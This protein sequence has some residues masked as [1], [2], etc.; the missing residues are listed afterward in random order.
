MMKFRIQADALYKNLTAAMKLTDNFS[1]LL[2]KIRGDFGDKKNWTVIGGLQTAFITQGTSK[3]AA[4]KDLTSKYAADKA[5]DFP[6][7]TI[8]IRS[9]DM[10]N[11]LVGGKAGNVSILTKKKLEY[12]TMIPYAG[13]HQTGTKRMAARKWNNIT[14]LQVKTWKKLIASYVVDVLRGKQEGHI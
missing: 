2:L 1:P 13:F 7:K 3:G 4:W 10:F 5:K 6:G 9:G 12:G 14:P 8:L 11:S